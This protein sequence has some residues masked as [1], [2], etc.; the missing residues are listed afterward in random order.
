MSTEEISK[1][2]NDLALNDKEAPVTEA[3]AAAAASATSESENPES[4]STEPVE[5]PASLYVGELDPSVNEALLFEIFSPIGQVSSIRVCRDAITKR[6]LGYAYVNF[7]AKNDGERALE[8][9]NY[10]PIKGRPCRI[11]WSQRDPSV[12]RGGSANIFIKNLHPAIDNKALHDTFSAF[13]DILSCKVATD[14][15][16]TSKGFGFVHYKTDDAAKAAIESVNGMLLN[17]REVYVGPHV[18]K[19]DR[20]NKL[21]ELKNNFT[22]VYV[23]NIDSEVTDQELNEL[24]A[25]IGAVTSAVVEKDQ[26]GNSKGFGFV[27]YE[28][29]E[30]AAK[31][32]E[33]LNDVELKSK[34]L[35]VG[36]AQKKRE[37]IEE[38]TKQHEAARLE[39]ISK[40]Q[41]VNLF[42]KNLDDSIEDE[43]LKEE[44]SAFGTITSAKVMTDDAGKSKGFGF[45]CFSSPEE[46]TKAV[47]EMNQRM[48]AG[49]PLYVAL[50]Q[51]KDVR[52]A[53][54]QQQMEAR[55]QMRL[56][57][58]AAHGVPNQFMQA[59]FYNQAGQ[60][61]FLPPGA[62]GP[63]NPQMM[64][65]Q[66][67][68]RP[69]QGIPPP[70]QG[71]WAGQG[72]NGQPVPVY[73]MPPFVGG[74]QGNMRGPNNRFYQNR[75][76]R[77]PRGPQS[78]APTSNV[79]Q[80]ASVL[81]S[82]PI[83]QQKRLLGEE[84]YPKVFSNPKLNQD[85]EAAGKITGMILDLDNT[86]ILQMLDDEE[87]FKSRFADAFSAYEEY[88][89]SN[90]TEGEAAAA[91]AA[92]TSA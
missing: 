22:N 47:A 67:I 27:N 40:Y 59:M 45:V 31:A 76:Q 14:E 65:Q 86:E 91:P 3:P 84:L 85:A 52:R 90:A 28:N 71:Q 34:K 8:E 18:S 61:G 33:K 41:G 42:I 43:K 70:P 51:R 79:A 74:P 1:T 11:M 19:K 37:R 78:D 89:N 12:R 2:L 68:P 6:S 57:Q 58:Q 83:E 21:E 53:Q 39:K 88:K 72:P 63:V 66:G 48:V 9:L 69:G 60:P 24:F 62:R 46:A 16:G 5:N 75:N 36:R 20:Q 7:H 10:S 64:M 38:L 55:N 25:T 80:L 87:V 50:A 32:V 44:F 92:E 82:Y 30:D 35:Y 81:P 4:A 13:G 15:F 54:L 29:H 73:G 17:D 23:K 49:K 77:G 56:Q 26:E